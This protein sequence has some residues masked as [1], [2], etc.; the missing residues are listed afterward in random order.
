MSH[1]LRLLF[2][3]LLLSGGMLPARTASA[4]QPSP[5]DSPNAIPGELVVGFESSLQ[6]AAFRAPA[7]AAGEGSRQLRRLG[8]T[9]VK[10]PPG[11]EQKYAR[12]LA[13][14]PGV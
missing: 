4:A 3:L 9:V 1:R 8:A 13:A 11:Q 2:T 12:E 14:Q 5:W 10:V 7:G 6:A